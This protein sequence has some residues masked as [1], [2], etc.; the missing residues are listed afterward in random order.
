MF[1]DGTKYV[2][3]FRLNEVTEPK[4]EP[5]GNGR[6]NFTE[7]DIIT[8]LGILTKADG[9]KQKGYFIDGELHDE[10]ELTQEETS[11]LKKIE[12]H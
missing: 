8:G 7:D 2:G 5:L 6:E 12:E 11:I 1:N 4:G 10:F 9:S 3:E